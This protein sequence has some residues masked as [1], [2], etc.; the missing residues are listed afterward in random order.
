MTITGIEFVPKAPQQG[1]KVESAEQVL[2]DIYELLEN[3]APA[4]YSEQLRE[5]MQSA[6]KRS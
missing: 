2:A 5:R 1:M 3:Y 6:L 4:W